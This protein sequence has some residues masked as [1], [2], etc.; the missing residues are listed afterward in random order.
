MW[1]YHEK[2]QISTDM[3]QEYLSGKWQY[4]SI[5]DFILKSSHSSYLAAYE[6][7]TYRVFRT[8][9]NYPEESIQY[10]SNL[11]V[12]PTVS[13]FCFGQFIFKIIF[14]QLYC[15]GV[16]TYFC[17]SASPKAKRVPRCRPFHRKGF[18]RI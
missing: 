3:W 18:F 16:C 11:H 10:W 1:K 17:R 12:L 9:G 8:P 5:L 15:V 13:S 6:D 7:G 4:W 14:I 2:F